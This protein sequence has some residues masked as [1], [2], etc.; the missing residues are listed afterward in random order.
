MFAPLSELLPGVRFDAPSWMTGTGPWDIETVAATVASRIAEA[1]EGSAVVVGH[2]TGGAIA[3]RIA[4]AHPEVVSGL[5][6]VDTGA[7]M[8]EHGDVEAILATIRTNWSE[9]LA[10][11]ILD[12]SFSDPV[13]ADDRASFLEYASTVDRQAALDV[14][15]SQHALDFAPRLPTLA[16]IPVEVVHGRLDPVRSVEQAEAFARLIGTAGAPLTLVDSGHTPVY[17]RPADV[18]PVVE[19]VVAAAYQSWTVPSARRL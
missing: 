2:S 13:S 3:Q 18:A 1:P 15:S 9:T 11:S 6:L 10:E 19:R 5:V 8:H 16:G 14:L 17:E 7:N 12:R 4:L